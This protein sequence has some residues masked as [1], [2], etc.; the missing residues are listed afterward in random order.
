MASENKRKN[1]AFV[2]VKGP[3]AGEDEEMADMVVRVW[4][5]TAAAEKREQCMVRNV[6]GNETE[7]KPLRE[8]Q[9]ERELNATKSTR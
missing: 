4:R 2:R 8:S 3:T 7:S 5:L 6:A 9:Q 1:L